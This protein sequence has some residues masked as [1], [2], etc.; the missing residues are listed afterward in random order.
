MYICTLYMDIRQDYKTLSLGMR[1]TFLV[2]YFPSF[3]KLECIILEISK[4]IQLPSL[5]QKT[6]GVEMKN[7]EIWRGLHVSAK[8]KYFGCPKYSG[9]ITFFVFSHWS[10][11]LDQGPLFT[12]LYLV[13]RFPAER[14]NQV[15]ADSSLC[16]GEINFSVWTTLH[17]QLF[18][19]KNCS[20]L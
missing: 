12:A 19:L 10:L 13:F 6:S 1:V 3:L 17:S 7:G 8:V 14:H 5:K 4:W 20:T 16:D 9:F 2:F 15:R 11:K 18:W